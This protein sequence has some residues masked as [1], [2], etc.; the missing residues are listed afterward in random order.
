[1]TAVA[2]PAATLVV[3]RDRPGLFPELLMV[4]RAAAMAFAGG[5]TVFPG[6][7]VDDADRA[8]AQT[9]DLP[10]IDEGA[11]RIAAIRET[12]E[13]AGLP[14]GLAT[15]P[16]PD[17]LRRLRAALH[18]GI[19]FG[20]ALAA[21]GATLDLTRLVPFARWR[22]DFAAAR[23]V[24][25]TRFYLARLPVDAPAPVVDGTENVRLWWSTAQGVLD[26]AMAGEV[27]IIFPTKRNLERLARFASFDAAADAARALP[28]RTVTPWLAMRDGEEHLCIPDDLGYPITSERRVDVRRG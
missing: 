12:I 10:D 24:Y 25:D 1:M 2:I 21:I 18:D 22:P 26:R 9:L 7:R 23:R 5:A 8:L 6:G 20:V 17:M 3:V 14:V 4:E 19:A 11:A 13:E 28:V 15:M 27:A 16:T